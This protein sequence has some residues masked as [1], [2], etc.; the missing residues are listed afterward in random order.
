MS[1]GR[2]SAGGR[3]RDFSWIIW[4]LVPLIIGAVGVSIVAAE[5]WRDA[6]I[7]LLLGISALIVG[8]LL[9][10]LFGLPRALQQDMTIDTGIAPGPR[11]AP[12]RA[13][14]NLEQISDW[15]TKILVGLGLTQ[16]VVAPTRLWQAAHTLA[17]AITSGPVTARAQ[18]LVLFVFVSFAVW[19]FMFSYLQTRLYLAATFYRADRAV[20]YAVTRQTEEAQIQA[21]LYEYEDEG[22]RD[23]IDAGEEYLRSYGRGVSPWVWVYLACAYGQKYKWKKDEGADEAALKTVRDKALDAT[24]QA[25]R[26]KPQF[27]GLLQSLWDPSSSSFVPDEDDLVVFLDDAEFTAL[28]DPSVTPLQTR[29][30][31]WGAAPRA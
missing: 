24:R 21:H 5:T 22:F 30:E 11:R 13:S 16:I 20:L 31:H 9:G 19:G 18:A 25:L 3:S 15:L 1:K 7:T 17:G 26:L 6:A 14:T 8:G 12:Y 2:G 23:A 27:R 4:T 28:L 29:D 10:F